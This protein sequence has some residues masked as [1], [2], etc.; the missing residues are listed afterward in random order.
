MVNIE[1]PL[2]VTSNDLLWKPVS[3][4]FQQ[5]R[6]TDGDPLLHVVRRQWS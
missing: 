2:V 3:I 4:A 1:D 5:Q 6:A